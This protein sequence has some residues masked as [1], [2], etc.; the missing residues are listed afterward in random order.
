VSGDPDLKACCSPSGP[1]FYAASV[2]DIISQANVS[3]ELHDSLEKAMKENER[4]T[5]E[6]ADQ[7]KNMELV[8]GRGS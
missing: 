7:I 3:K 2:A 8:G 1:L 6:L 5:D 4:L